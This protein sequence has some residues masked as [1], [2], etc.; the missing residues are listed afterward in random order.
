MKI[1]YVY[2][3]LR[4][5]GTPYYVGKGTGYESLTIRGR[6]RAYSPFHNVKRPKDFSRILVQDYQ[7]EKEALLVERFFISLYGRLDL[8]TGCLRN[9][10]DGGEGQSGR[11]VS[12]SQRERQ[13]KALIGRKAAAS[14]IKR[15]KENPNS[16]VFEKGRDVPAKTKERISAAL[17]VFYS[18]PKNREMQ[19][20]KQRKYKTPEART[21]ATKEIRQRANAKYRAKY[22]GEKQ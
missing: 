18:N 22:V 1:F 10:T 9:F 6:Y 14:T 13:S 2:L 5:D 11:I 21:E 20:S 16:G 15:Q 19:S 4:E 12:S 7:D 17:K 3:W 8:G